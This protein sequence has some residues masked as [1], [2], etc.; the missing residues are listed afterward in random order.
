MTIVMTMESI[1][2]LVDSIGLWDPRRHADPD[3]EFDYIDISSV[4]REAKCV[5]GISRTR[6]AE[7][8]SRARQRVHAGDVL[9]STVRPNL[10][11]VAVVPAGLQDGTA[12]TGFCVLRPQAKRL[13]ARYLF[14]WVRT[15]QFID[16]MARLATGA[17][18]PAVTDRTILD[19]QIPLPQSI[20]EQRRIANILVEADILRR[21]RA[22]ASRLANDLVPSLFYEL[23]EDGTRFPSVPLESLLDPKRPI[24]Y[25]ILMPGEDIES[26]VPY[27]RVTDMKGDRIAVQQL[28]RTAPEI[29]AAYR[30]SR[31]VPGDVL[32]S[33]RGHV[34][35]TVV[36]PDSLPC[37]NI[38]QDTARLSLADPSLTHF[39]TWYLRSSFASHW[40]DGRTKGVAVRGINLGELKKLP[41]PQADSKSVRKFN[42]TVAEWLPLRDRFEESKR[43]LEGLF[44]SLLQR[45]FHGDL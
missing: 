17:S 10:N 19:S 7:A 29:D 8:P 3:H 44:D 41:V 2:S 30:R 18:Y 40:M 20:E 42:D 15:P 39:L 31:I 23:F 28:R 24:T 4:N 14:Y 26:G 1:R 5:D 16:T 37:A 45:A 13:D 21:K 22:E 32:V 33:I 36:V 38:T 6:V 9:V 27:V 34:G 35:R 11:A 43:Y 25:G 12:S